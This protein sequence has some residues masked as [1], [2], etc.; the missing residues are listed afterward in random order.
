MYKTFHFSV[1]EPYTYFLV[2][3]LLL[4]IRDIFYVCMATVISDRKKLLRCLI[5]KYHRPISRLRTWKY[6]EKIS[7]EQPDELTKK[8]LIERL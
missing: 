2:V 7:L 1:M 8:L 5:G 6:M 3:F 4:E